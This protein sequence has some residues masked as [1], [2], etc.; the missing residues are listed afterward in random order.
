MGK[1][2]IADEF[3]TDSFTF[4]VRPNSN[5]AIKCHLFAKHE[6]AIQILGPGLA[7]QVDLSH[8]DSALISGGGGAEFFITAT[9][10]S[11][12]WDL[13][14]QAFSITPKL[15]RNVKENCPSTFFNDQVDKAVEKAINLIEQSFS[16]RSNGSTSYDPVRDYGYLV[17]YLLVKDMVGLRMRDKPGFAYR[18]FRF[19]NKLR[20]KNPNLIPIPEVQQANELVFWIE[21]MFGHLFMNPGDHNKLLL[22]ASR[23]ISKSYIET[24]RA[25]LVSPPEWS[26]IHRMKETNVAK[27]SSIKVYDQLVINIVMELVGSFQYLTGRAFAGV[28]ETIEGKF[29]DSIAP[30]RNL[31]ATFNAR[32]T[33]NARAT[34]D[35]AM[36]HNSPTGFIFRQASTGFEYKGIRIAKGDLMCVLCDTA[37]KDPSVFK[38]PEIFY[39]IEMSVRHQG[40][41]LAFGSPDFDPSEFKPHENHHPCFGQYMGRVIIA[42]MLKGLES[43]PQ[44]NIRSTNDSYVDQ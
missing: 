9:N 1:E 7:D 17:T 40:D 10:K 15:H 36:R 35:E 24:I 5:R 41:Y 8:Y 2:I 30:S 31:L 27:S 28:I 33:L 11:T 22:L 18:L 37:S 14:N 25:S 39:D 20:G 4:T 13:L 26:L 23:M 3:E 6:D 38:T 29:A 12:Q 43:L 21:V 19:T 34:L 32:M 44:E 42:K 16:K